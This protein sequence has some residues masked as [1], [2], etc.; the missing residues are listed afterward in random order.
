MKAIIVSQGLLRC[1]TVTGPLCVL[2]QRSL[3]SSNPPDVYQF[4]IAVT[5]ECQAGSPAWSH[6]VLRTRDIC[7]AVCL[8]GEASPI[9]DRSYSSSAPPSL[10]G[11]APSS[12][13]CSPSLPGSGRASP[14]PIPYE[15]P[16]VFYSQPINVCYRIDPKTKRIN[17]LVAKAINGSHR[18]RQNSLGDPWEFKKEKHKAGHK[19]NSSWSGVFS[20]RD[21]RRSSS[22]DSEGSSCWNGSE[23][24]ESGMCGYGQQALLMIEINSISN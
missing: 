17:A 9:E 6:V 8:A 15:D 22:T 23:G 12:G 5:M 2:W 11:S 7:E 3:V 16:N 13:R 24:T 1:C 10:F 14:M 19:R 18:E 20:R 4:H 21:K